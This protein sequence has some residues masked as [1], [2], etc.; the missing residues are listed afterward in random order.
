[1]PGQ[2]EIAAETAP[3]VR[4]KLGQEV[5]DR[6]L[7]GIRSGA[8]PIGGLL[9]SE[10]ELMAQ[11][12]VGR[13]AVREGLQALERM[14]LV[15]IQHGE[16]ARVRALSADSVISQISETAV[17]LLAVDGHLLDHLKEARLAFE[18][19]MA[20][21]AAA[22]ATEADIAALRAALD[23][24][25]GS[26]GD[27]VGF[28]ETDLA[29][30]RTIAAVSGNPVYVAVSQA[31]LQWLTRFHKDLVRAPGAEAVTLDEHTRLFDCIA[32]HDP[33]GAEQAIREHLTRANESYRRR[34][35]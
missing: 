5:Q 16:G 8:H 23:A 13:P 21:A 12:G 3:I 6:L 30:H 11:F 26:I 31:M 28:L 19:A 32:R 25:R 2:R 9:P 22:R 18:V 20:R 15:S 34:A 24:H 10:R 35:G 4:R 27:P 17:H 7:A 1:M 14:G 29:L 33:D